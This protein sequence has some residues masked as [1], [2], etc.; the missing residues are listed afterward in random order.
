[1]NAELDALVRQLLSHW[2]NH[3]KDDAQLLAY[4]DDLEDLVAECGI[5][6]VVAAVRASNTRCRF[7][8]EPCELRALL[9]SA[10]QYGQQCNDPNCS[11]C[12][13]NGLKMVEV[14]SD[15]RHLALYPRE[16]TMKVAKRCDCRPAAP[17]HKEPTSAK[18]A[19]FIEAQF[20]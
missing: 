7:L 13:G 11:D 3:K 9:P 15:Q 17:A 8:P 12:H 2:P 18:A 6:R 14:P 5:R 1:V 20:A 10:E 19:P 16:T 4:Y